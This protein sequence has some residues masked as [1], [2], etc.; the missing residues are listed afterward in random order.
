MITT[1]RS[2]PAPPS[3]SARAVTRGT[4]LVVGDSTPLTRHCEYPSNSGALWANVLDTSAATDRHTAG[5]RIV[6]PPT[7]RSRAG[8]SASPDARVRHQNDRSQRGIRPAVVAPK[9]RDPL[10]VEQRRAGVA[11]SRV[12]ARRGVAMP[13]SSDRPG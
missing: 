2:A 9:H 13:A 1:V 5:P 12:A 4:T 11:G 7:C 6:E 3:W 8:D 10:G